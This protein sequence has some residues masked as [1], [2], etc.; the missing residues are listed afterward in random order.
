MKRYGIEPVPNGC[1][2]ANVGACES[3]VMRAVRKGRWSIRQL[4]PLKYSTYYFTGGDT[5]SAEP[6][7][8]GEIVEPHPTYVNVAYWRMWFG[9]VFAHESSRWQV[10]PDAVPA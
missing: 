6:G 4:L 1:G 9:R 10:V 7:H 2:D 3:C 5:I 8:E